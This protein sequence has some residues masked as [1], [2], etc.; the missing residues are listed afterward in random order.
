MVKFLLTSYAALLWCNQWMMHLL[1][2]VNG[3]KKTEQSWF[4]RDIPVLH[5]AA[6]GVY[7]GIACAH[8][9]RH[10]NRMWKDRRPGMGGS[11]FRSNVKVLRFPF[12]AGVKGPTFF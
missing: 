11:R 12:L 3:K 8:K 5:F 4:S 1:Q 7:L 2:S 9:K 10:A 6:L